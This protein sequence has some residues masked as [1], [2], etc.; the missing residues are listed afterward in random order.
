MDKCLYCNINLFS[1]NQNVYAVDGK[2]ITLLTTTT[3]EDLP[4]VLYNLVPEG[5]TYSIQL[6]TDPATGEM[7]ASHI[8]RLETANYGIKHINIYLVEAQ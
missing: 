2:E 4:E 8:K 6:A 3:I 7:V 5:M 1:M